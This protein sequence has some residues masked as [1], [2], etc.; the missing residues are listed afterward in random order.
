MDFSESWVSGFGGMVE[1]VRGSDL[2]RLERFELYL[3][4]VRCD[5]EN[6]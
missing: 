5:G 1:A 2:G 4:N 6:E 3:N